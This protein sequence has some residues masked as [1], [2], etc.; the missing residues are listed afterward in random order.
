M[1]RLIGFSPT[2]NYSTKHP[3]NQRFVYLC[4]EVNPDRTMLQVMETWTKF[5]I[6]EDEGVCCVLK[7]W[8]GRHHMDRIWGREI[9]NIISKE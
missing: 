2:T 5:F 8:N 3:V 6:I 1:G 4:G 7:A 9:A